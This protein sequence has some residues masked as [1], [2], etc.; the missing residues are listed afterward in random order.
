MF[1]DFSKE[2][3]VHKKWN[4]QHSMQDFDKYFKYSDL[5][6]VQAINTEYIVERDAMPVLGVKHLLF[7]LALQFLDAG[8]N[9][10]A[11]AVFQELKDDVGVC[12]GYSVLMKQICY[13]LI[14]EGM[15]PA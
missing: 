14:Q 6:P 10:F 5:T 13:R 1:L 2:A 11:H 4:V 8:M 12:H 7:V 15:K 3:N 9:V